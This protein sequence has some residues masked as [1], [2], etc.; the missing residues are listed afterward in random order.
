MLVGGTSAAFVV[1]QSLKNEK[2]PVGVPRFEPRAIAP[3]CDCPTDETT[4]QLRLR[5][6]D[7]VTAEIV[8]ADGGAVRTLADGERFKRGALALT[9]NGTDENGAVVPDGRYR[10]KVELARADRTMLLPTT[11]TVDTVAPRLRLVSV[12]PGELVP[13]G[14]IGVRYRANDRA[15]AILSVR[16]DD[17]P[18]TDVN[19][20]RYRPRGGAKINWSGNVGGEPLPPG[21]YTLVLRVRDSV[22][23]LSEPVTAPLTIVASG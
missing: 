9:W 11:I 7:R 2:S 4:V 21:E 1:T 5:K 22:G 12:R 19:T 13:G 8:N 16:G 3:T 17:L 10:L 23:N 14:K 15:Q 20:G 6:A 18:E